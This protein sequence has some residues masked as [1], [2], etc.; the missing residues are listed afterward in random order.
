MQIRKKCFF[1][2]ENI[3]QKHILSAKTIPKAAYCSGVPSS[4][5]HYCNLVTM[6]NAQVKNNQRETYFCDFIKKRETNKLVIFR[7]GKQTNC[8]LKRPNI[9]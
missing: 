7:K 4:C 3:I 6:Y 1:L 8:P 5:S 2:L 9:K